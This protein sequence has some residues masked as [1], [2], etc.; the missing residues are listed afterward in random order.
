V[1]VPQVDAAALTVIAERIRS[2]IESLPAPADGSRVTVSIGAALYPDDA[3][4]RE[5]LFK[6]ADA[7][8]YEAKEAGRNRV[9][10]PSARITR[11]V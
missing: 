2:N 1:I 5:A 10:A 7:R 9:I 8:L 6:A 3:R 11:A 4:D